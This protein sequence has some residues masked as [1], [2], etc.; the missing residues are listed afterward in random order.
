MIHLGSVVEE[1]NIF[2]LSA[3]SKGQIKVWVKI[4]GLRFQVKDLFFF[5]NKNFAVVFVFKTAELAEK[6][7]QFGESSLRKLAMD[8][9]AESIFH[10]EG[11][12][13]KEKRKVRELIKERAQN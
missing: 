7:K 12:D 2:F 4:W 5:S 13:Y 10:F 11:E 9:P 3:T 6:M 1:R 8:A